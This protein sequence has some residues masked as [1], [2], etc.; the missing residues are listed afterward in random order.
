MRKRSDQK[1]LVGRAGTEADRG[2][3]LNEK[4]SNIVVA[5][6]RELGEVLKYRALTA[7]YGVPWVKKKRSRGNKLCGRGRGAGLG[8]G[9]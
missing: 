5:V 1:G 7:K 4:G 3:E 8:T 9:P 2:G 6:N